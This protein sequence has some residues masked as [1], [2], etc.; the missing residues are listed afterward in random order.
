MAETNEKGYF[1]Y[2]IPKKNYD[3]W[4]S[5]EIKDI[6][7]RIIFL[8][9]NIM[10]E[11]IS[12]KEAIRNILR[13]NKDDAGIPI[14][15]RVP[16]KIFLSTAGGEEETGFQIIDLVL[17]SKTPVYIINSG[18]S[19]SMGSLINLAGHKRY[20]FENTRFLI[21]DGSGMSMGSQLKVQ[22]EVEFMVKA[23]DRIKNY[24]LER[25]AITEEEYESKKRVEWYMF[26]DEAKEKGV[27]DYIIG[28]DCSLEEL[29]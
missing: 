22:D 17:Q 20:A 8:D 25:T 6:K 14:E 19:Y 12:V 5:L 13:F 4:D 3:F 27:V 24:I 10:S 21:H 23:N 7:N 2:K 11:S 15:E 9:S 1:D 26:A 28:K 29:L 16:I 18:Y